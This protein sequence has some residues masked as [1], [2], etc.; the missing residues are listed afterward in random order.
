LEF[1]VASKDCRFNN[2]LHI[3]EPHCAVKLAIENGEMSP[4]RYDN[5]LQMIAEIRDQNY[6]ELNKDL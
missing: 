6:W 5:Y 3:N 2:C 1:F 4:L